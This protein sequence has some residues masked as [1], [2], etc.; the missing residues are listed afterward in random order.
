[1]RCTLIVGRTHGQCV[2]VLIIFVKMRYFG[3]TNKNILALV[4][5]VAVTLGI[6]FFVFTPDSN[7]LIVSVVFILAYTLIFLG[8]R[9]WERF[10]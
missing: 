6:R 5:A 8:V 4:V 1:M 7:L 3:R 9:V 2:P 10:K